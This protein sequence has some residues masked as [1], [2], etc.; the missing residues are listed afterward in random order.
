MKSWWRRQRAFILFLVLFGLFRTAVADWNPVPTGSMR[1]TVIE[2]DVVLVNRLAWQLKLPLT[3]V[4]LGRWSAPARGDIATFGS[5]A[6]GTRLLKRVVG[7]PGDEIELRDG[8]LWVN[9]EQIAL[10]EPY[11]LQEP[12][13]DG[14]QLQAWRAQEQLGTRRHALQTL[15]EVAALRDGHWTVPANHYFMLGDNRDNSHDSRYF[16]PV[17]RERLIGRVSRLLVS[18]NPELYYLPRPERVGKAL[19]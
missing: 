4:V 2:G 12:L 3:D 17:P 10:S 18:L 19:D 13:P 8:R 14:G 1:P 11:H 16:G 9:G 15:P 5:P 6:D 7:L